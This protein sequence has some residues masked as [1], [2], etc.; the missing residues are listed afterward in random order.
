MSTKKA[1]YDRGK[2]MYRELEIIFNSTDGIAA[3]YT[4][5]SHIAADPP[6]N[7][8]LINYPTRRYRIIIMFWPRGMLA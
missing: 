2:Q 5:L 7:N 6:C 4:K 3:A 8:V 1:R